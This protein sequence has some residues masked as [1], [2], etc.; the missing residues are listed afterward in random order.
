MAGLRLLPTGSGLAEGDTE[1]IQRFFLDPG[2]NTI[3]GSVV[4]RLWAATDANG[5]TG[6][7]R[8]GLFDC[9]W[10]GLSDC[11][12][13]SIE[14]VDAVS[15]WVGTDFEELTFDFGTMSHGFGGSRR[16]VLRV[17]AEGAETVHTAFDSTPH[18]SR[19][20]LPMS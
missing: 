14:V 19:I 15:Q 17:V 6:S 9:N 3:T 1:H 20:S 16:L 7:V 5:A 2:G 8:A 12:P 11:N 13:I 4:L 18:P 10:T